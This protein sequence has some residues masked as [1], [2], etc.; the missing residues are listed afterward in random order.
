MI[1]SKISNFLKEIENIL[2]QIS[3]IRS[4]HHIKKF[5]GSVN[6]ECKNFVL[7]DA[8]WDSPYHYVRLLIIKKLYFSYLTYRFM[9]YIIIIYQNINY[10][11]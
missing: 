1:S 5:A 7:I 11:L 2:Y 4:N 9:G 3:R 10:N 6:E 8:L